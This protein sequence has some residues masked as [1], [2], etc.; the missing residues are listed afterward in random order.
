MFGGI[1][2][3]LM[4]D[5]CIFDFHSLKWVKVDFKEPEEDQ[6]NNDDTQNET[7]SYA[8][9]LH[10]NIMNPVPEKRFAHS[11]VKYKNMLIL[12]GGEEKFNISRK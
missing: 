7:D 6:K 2:N 1:S 12:Y 11:L 5:I 3:S 10:G 9:D 4:N 8:I